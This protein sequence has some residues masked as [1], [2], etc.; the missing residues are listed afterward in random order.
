MVLSRFQRLSTLTLP[1]G[2]RPGDLAAVHPPAGLRGLTISTDPGET[3]DLAPLKGLAQLNTLEITDAHVTNLAALSALPLLRVIWFQGKGARVDDLAGL[4]TL[5]VTIVSFLEAPLARVPKLPAHVSSFV[6]RGSGLTDI[7]ALAGHDELATVSLADN[8]VVDLAVLC[9]LKAL[10]SLN[11]EGTKVS[12]L[13]P[14]SACSELDSLDLR[15]TPVRDLAPLAK[16]PK[17]KILR[18]TSDI[19][20]A[21]V[22]AFQKASPKTKIDMN[23]SPPSARP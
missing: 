2:A 16:L 11:L 14:L 17:L 6:A 5:P 23:P 22:D 19:P 12:S 7:S 9:K 20:K 21:T 4:A 10:S 13:A 3:I 1:L 8:P 15:R 18:L